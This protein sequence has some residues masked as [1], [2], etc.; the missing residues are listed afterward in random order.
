MRKGPGLAFRSLTCCAFHSS[1]SS[2]VVH[3]RWKF[4]Q[5][6]LALIVDGSQS[7]EADDFVLEKNFTKQTVAAFAEKNLFVNGGEASYVQY[8]SSV[9][10]SATFNSV[11]DFNEFVDADPQ[12]RAST[13]TAEGIEEGTE[14]LLTNPASAL[15]MIVITDGE[16]QDEPIIAADAARA[17][18]IEVF[19][20]G[21]GGCSCDIECPLICRCGCRLT[22]SP[23]RAF[24]RAL[25]PNS[26]CMGAS[27]SDALEVNSG[28]NGATLI[29]K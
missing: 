28:R 8:S 29:S 11:A 27:G 26:P 18:G 6:N 2:P 22:E 10:T 12:A 19:A 23:S 24:V 3:E 1:H 17:E 21:V 16:S 14:V 20:V 15:F 9:V 5:V 7:I 13:R 25:A 4:W